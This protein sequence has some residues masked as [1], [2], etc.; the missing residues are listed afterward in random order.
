MA[1]GLSA[2]VLSIGDVAD[3]LGISKLGVMRLISRGPLPGTKVGQDGEWRVRS[4]ALDQYVANGAPDA[5]EPEFDVSA[6]GDG[7]PSWFKEPWNYASDQLSNELANLSE[8]VLSDAEFAART[9]SGPFGDS[10]IMVDVALTA[11]MRSLLNGPVAPLESAL[12]GV[13]RPRAKS[14]GDLWLSRALRTAV[15]GRLDSMLAVNSAAGLAQLRPLGPDMRPRIFQLYS[16][17]VAYGELVSFAVRQILQQSFFA[18]SEFRQRPRP[19][20]RGG[21]GDNIAVRVVYRLPV[22][23]YASAGSLQAIASY[24]AF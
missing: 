14:W 11:A 13:G 5:D 8:T 6:G 1:T 18:R 10:S 12:P 4:A 22:S 16:G 17:P 7:S 9:A 21:L 2:A 23:A 15:A 24:L 20:T 3:A 19:E